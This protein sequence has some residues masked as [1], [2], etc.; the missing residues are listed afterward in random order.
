MLSKRVRNY[1]YDARIRNHPVCCVREGKALREDMGYFHQ[2]PCH[3]VLTNGQNC[4]AWFCPLCGMSYPDDRIEG[5][6]GSRPCPDCGR[7]RDA[8]IR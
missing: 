7:M 8:E 5:L 2:G 1:L 6:L 4:K 3:M